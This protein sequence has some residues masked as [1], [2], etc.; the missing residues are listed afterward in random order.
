MNGVLLA[1]SATTLI[2]LALISS[3]SRFRLKA[4]LDKLLA[5][6]EPGGDF[7]IVPIDTEIARETAA[8]G[9]SLRDPADRV[10]V[11]T[12]R[13]HGLRLVTSDQRIIASKLCPVVE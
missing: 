7:R 4:P 2:E 1:L 8:L 13:V 9:D 11:A 10:I 5:D 6:L 3:Y 12:A